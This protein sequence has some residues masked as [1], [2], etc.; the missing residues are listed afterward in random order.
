MQKKVLLIC[1]NEAIGV[2]TSAKIKVAAT[3]F[4]PYISLASLA[5]SLFRDGADAHILDLSVEKNPEL[6]LCETINE[7]SPDFVGVTFTTALFKSAQHIGAKVKELRPQAAL[8][9]GG[10]HSTTLPE[11]V[12]QNSVFDIVCVGE[13]EETIREIVAGHDLK[14]IQGIGY[15]DGGE[16]KI[17]PRRPLIFDLDNLPL[18]AWHLYDKNKYYVPRIVA[19]RHPVGAMETSR[20]CVFGCIFCNKTVFERRFRHKSPER[21]VDE[22]EYMLKSGFREIHIWDDGFSTDL[23]RAKKICELIIKRRLKFAWNLPNGLRVDC[24]DEE[25]LLLLK[26]AG[27]YRISIGVESGNQEVLDDVNKNLTL[28][29]IR[30]AV[31]LIK[32][33]SIESLGFFILGFP[34]DT[35]ATMQESIDFAKELDLD[36]IKTGIIMPLPGTPLFERWKSEGRIVSYD[37]SKYIFHAAE[38]SV[39]RHPTLP[40]ETIRRYY[41]KFYRELYL[42]PRFIWKRFIRGWKTGD[43]FY[44]VYYFLRTLPE[45]FKK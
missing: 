19:R 18:P 3:Q 5:G 22:I 20:G 25:L 13:G 1:P 40:Y 7:L 30:A 15:R 26:R 28:D 31:R 41:D 6:V 21:V 37:W 43:I 14:N 2:Y 33:V 11:D 12:L 17:N 45:W 27:C 29:Q 23:E 10:V 16:I 32:K 34:K 9:A 24:L 35:E 8:I 36:L 44:D 38:N 39:Y 42:S 4:I